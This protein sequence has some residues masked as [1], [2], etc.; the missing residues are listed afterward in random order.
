[1]CLSRSVIFH[2][3]NG[4]KSANNRV[5]GRQ[6]ALMDRDP[7]S[8]IIGR[9]R[10]LTGLL[11]RSWTNLWLMSE[12]HWGEEFRK[13]HKEGRGANRLERRQILLRFVKS[14]R[15]NSQSNAPCADPIKDL[16]HRNKSAK[17][18]GQPWNDYQSIKVRESRSEEK[19]QF[20]RLS[21]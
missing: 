17:K 5:E 1:M 14:S 8:W 12:L 3:F 7:H 9:P 18:G 4:R 16:F 2:L 6:P 15:H 19:Q 21:G 13:T 11:P 20:S 10:N